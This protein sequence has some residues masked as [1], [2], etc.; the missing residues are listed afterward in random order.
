L[1]P[2]EALQTAT[3][4]PALYFGA[5]KDMGTLEVG[6]FADFVVLDANPL[7]DIHNTQ[8]IDAVVLKGRYYSRRDLNAM[9]EAAA[10]MSAAAR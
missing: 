10:Q 5:Q 2:L 9:L 4:N 6:K 3:R 1:T 8:T 7:E